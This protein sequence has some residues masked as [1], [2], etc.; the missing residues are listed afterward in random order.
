M[1]NT[2][3]TVSPYSG[4]DSSAMA[5]SRLV[6]NRAPLADA[7]LS[8]APPLLCRLSFSSGAALRESTM[9]TRLRRGRNLGGIDSQVFLPI[10]CGQVTGQLVLPEN[11]RARRKLQR[12][13]EHLCVGKQLNH[14]GTISDAQGNAKLMRA[15]APEAGRSNPLQGLTTAFILAGSCVLDVR[16]LKYAMSAGSFHGI[17][18]PFPMPSCRVAATT[19]WNDFCSIASIAAWLLEA[20]LLPVASYTARDRSRDATQQAGGG[21]GAEKSGT[22]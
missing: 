22:Q 9:L 11:V 7:A 10:T 19:S 8:V 1:M 17:V 15:S 21:G 5:L 16:S 3:S 18:P 13:P 14:R 4:P 12:H 20:L 6:L 2:V